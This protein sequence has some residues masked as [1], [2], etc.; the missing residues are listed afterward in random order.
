MILLLIL[1]PF[2][3]N[4]IVFEPYFEVPLD[5]DEYLLPSDFDND[6]IVQH[7]DGTYTLHSGDETFEF[8]KIDPIFENVPVIKE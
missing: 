5:R 7:K 3:S 1:L 2:L 6:Y 4:S 8:S